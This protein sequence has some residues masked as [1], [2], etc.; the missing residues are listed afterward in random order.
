MITEDKKKKKVL[1]LAVTAGIPL[2]T[3]VLFMAYK[4]P[5]YLEREGP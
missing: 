4:P 5:G 1:F 2:V 3:P